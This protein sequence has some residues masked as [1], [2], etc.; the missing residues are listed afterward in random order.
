MVG[1]GRTKAGSTTNN[2][3]YFESSKASGGVKELT[4]SVSFAMTF[5][6]TFFMAG[7]TGYYFGNYFLNLPLP[8]S[9]MIA[10][11]FIVAT[12]IIETTLFIIK[13]NKRPLKE[14]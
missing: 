10:L 6:F 12:I 3:Y 5:I 2:A 7:L 9:L 11:L 4:D 14:N 1:I 8:Q 13:Q